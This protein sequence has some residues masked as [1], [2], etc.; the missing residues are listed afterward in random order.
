MS[1]YSPVSG[2][3]WVVRARVGRSRRSGGK[4][5]AASCDCRSATRAS[6][7]A[8]VVAPLLRVLAANSRAFGRAARASRATRS[9]APARCL[10]RDFAARVAGL[11]FSSRFACAGCAVLVVGVINR[12]RSRTRPSS[13]CSSTRY[14]VRFKLAAPVGPGVGVQR[15]QV[16][17]RSAST[18]GRDGRQRR[19]PSCTCAVG[20][21]F[22]RLRRAV[23]PVGDDDAQP[24]RPA[25]GPLRVDHPP[26][27]GD[28]TLVRRC[29]TP[30]TGRAAQAGR[31]C[32]RRED[33]FDRRVDRVLQ[34]GGSS[35]STPAARSRANASMRDCCHRNTSAA[36]AYA[37]SG[38]RP[39]AVRSRRPPRRDTRPP[40]TSVDVRAR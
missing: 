29:R 18:R 2:W 31:P 1:A 37:P 34:L 11:L 25:L 13:P 3:W 9:R 22:Q 24:A 4:C 5:Q 17:W 35:R 15:L 20:V 27:P 33:P 21:D 30:A 7:F 6:S 12:R 23:Q 38:S 39:A 19:R 40:T 8:E 28:D 32:R 26:P 14:R 10:G 36:R 16:G